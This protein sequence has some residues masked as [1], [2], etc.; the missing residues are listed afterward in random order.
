VPAL[1][2]L[3]GP[4]QAAA[5]ASITKAPV[6]TVD[7]P[8]GEIGYRS[9]GNGPPLVARVSPNARLKVYAAAAHGFFVQHRRDFLDRVQRFLGKPRR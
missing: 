1:G 5:P 7:T 2:L 9:V 4:A 6:R 3:A 8:R